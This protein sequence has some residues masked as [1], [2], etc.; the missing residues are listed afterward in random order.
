VREEQFGPVLPVLKYSDLD[1]AIARAND[2]EYGLGGT[3][4]GTDL[5]RAFSVAQRITSGTVW[6]NKHLDLPPD[7]PF[8]GARQSGF[9][10][11]MGQEGLEEF[12]QARI[13]NMA[14]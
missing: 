6:I 13:I 12:T 7:I 10:A 1:D 8:A 4:W 11:E 9:G 2:S 3:V 5:N 14:K